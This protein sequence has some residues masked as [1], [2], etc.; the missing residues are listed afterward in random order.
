MRIYDEIRPRSLSEVKG[1]DQA[2]AALAGLRAKFGGLGG[3]AL[4]ITGKSGCGKSLI[5]SLLANELAVDWCIETVDAGEITAG[6][7]DTFIR[8]SHLC[9]MGSEKPGRV[10][11]IE[12]AHGLRADIMRRMLTWLQALPH[13]ST[14]IFTTTVDGQAALFDSKM[15]ASPLVS[16]CWPVRLSTQGMA[17]PVAAFLRERF[18]S[19]GMN[20]KPIG[21][22]VRKMQ[23]AKNNVRQAI[24]D[25]ASSLAAS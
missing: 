13:V 24:H 25:I 15:D 23:D 5:A 2:L 19:I 17:E 9:G 21:W 18:A 1:Q 10:Y 3:Q 4:W 7:M 16:R 12:E 8:G 11:I 22:F 20:G 6:V 14:V